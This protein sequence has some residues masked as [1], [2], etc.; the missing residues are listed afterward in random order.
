MRPAMLYEVSFAGKGFGAMLALEFISDGVL[1]DV[2]IERRFGLVSPGAG[3]AL[4][5]PL[6]GVSQQ[7]LPQATDS[8]FP[9]DGA[10]VGERP[11]RHVDLTSLF[12][13]SVGRFEDVDPLDGAGEAA[14]PL[15]LDVVI[16][17]GFGLEA[18]VA[19]R[20]AE[21]LFVE[22]RQQVLPQTWKAL[23]VANRTFVG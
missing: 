8:L 1:L 2:K 7:V 10:L 17:R 23:P 18:A 12:R 11:P 15:P 22:V 9:A 5:G 19:T 16:E 20:A 4:E 13:L 6:V 14:E 3:G 21:G